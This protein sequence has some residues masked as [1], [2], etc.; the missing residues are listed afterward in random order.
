[1][2]R[3]RDGFISV[4]SLE[5]K[6]W[7]SFCGAVGLDALVAAQFPEGAAEVAAV[8]AQVQAVL[9]QRSSQ[10]W[11]EHFA[12]RDCCVEIGRLQWRRARGKEGD[13]SCGRMPSGSRTHVTHFS[14]FLHCLPCALF[15]MLFFFVLLLSVEQ[16][17]GLPSRSP[18]LA[19]RG[20]TLHVAL[21][22]NEQ[23]EVASPPLR[24]AGLQPNTRPAPQ[25]GQ[26]NEM[27]LAKL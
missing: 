23:L 21:P 4:G 22:D 9:E 7:A 24:M 14:C 15:W 12:K 8:K 26:H 5:P 27:L 11:K 25:L 10:E 2:Y 20:V 13:V 17:E 1:M 3:T 19:A 6:F 18:Q 16:P